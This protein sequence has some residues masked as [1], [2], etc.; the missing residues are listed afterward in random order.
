V[1]NDSRRPARHSSTG[2][3][4]DGC[5]VQ[6]LGDLTLSAPLSGGTGLL[7]RAGRGRPSFW[8]VQTGDKIDA[9][10]TLVSVALLTMAL[11]YGVSAQSAGG[12]WVR[13][14]PPSP[15]VWELIGRLFPDTP[16]LRRDRA[17]RGFLDLS[18]LAAGTIKARTREGEILG[19]FVRFLPVLDN[20]VLNADQP[21]DRLIV[22]EM[23]Q[24][25]YVARDGGSV[26][27]ETREGQP[28]SEFQRC[29]DARHTQFAHL[30]EIRL[31]A[32]ALCEGALFWASWRG[33]PT[34]SLDA[35]RSGTL[36]L[37]QLG[38]LIVTLD[39]TTSE[40]S[41][42]IRTPSLG[43]GAGPRPR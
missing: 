32:A 24:V 8:L 5:L 34:I 35:N 40:L 15:G 13:P 36:V 21:P 1:R 10:R 39:P 18:I 38:T 2:V 4:R 28:S 31:Q 42:T 43:E 11:A 41:A 7:S 17:F 19:N 14:Y 16:E 12:E 26:R 30:A 22:A 23:V 6:R 9:M 33:Q 25:M 37:D 27:L 3:I 20:N 29:Y